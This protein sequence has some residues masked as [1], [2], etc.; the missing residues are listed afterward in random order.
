MNY[1]R[2]NN[3]KEKRTIPI[4]QSYQHINCCESDWHWLLTTL[5]EILLFLEKKIEMWIE[6]SW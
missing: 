4:I 6:D 1:K 3:R 2:E 5:Q